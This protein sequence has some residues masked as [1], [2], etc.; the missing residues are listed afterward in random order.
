MS[1]L[2]KYW[3]DLDDEQKQKFA[4]GSGLS[5]GYINVHLIHKRKTPPLNKLMAMANASNG[6]LTF[7]GLCD[8]FLSEVEECE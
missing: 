8:F 1:D 5:V 6:E 2:Y 4:Q 3:T 7:H